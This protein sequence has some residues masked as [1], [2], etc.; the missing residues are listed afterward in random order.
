[1]TPR[2]LVERLIADNPS[3]HVIAEEH[4]KRLSGIL[5]YQVKSGLSSH[6]VTPKVLRFFADHVK[7]DDLTAE[8][9]GGHTTVALAALAKHHL[10]VTDD[11]A[12][13]ELIKQYMTQVGIPADKVTFIVESSDT[14]L[15]R[16]P[17]DQVFDFVF[18]DGEHSYPYP[19]IDW[20][21]L[22]PRLKVGGILGVD[23]TEIRAVYDLCVFLKENK[24]YNF[25]QRLEDGMMSRRYGANFYR[26]L[27]DDHRDAFQQP[28]V[29]RPAR[30]AT[31]QEK[32]ADW[33]WHRKKVWP[34]D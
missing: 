15:P 34:W 31:W 11:A 23:N 9:G 12:S 26:K 14:A 29:L 19:V 33:R 27:R 28:Y 4:A 22:D 24:T 7:S 30:R 18:L 17:T 5:G 6:A 2:D 20:H 10:C 16:L 13:V 21:Y 32:L 25:L 1:L 3:L 8:T